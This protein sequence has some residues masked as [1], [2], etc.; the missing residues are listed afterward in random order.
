MVSKLIGGGIF[1][2]GLLITISFPNIRQYQPVSMSWTGV[3]VGV[4]LMGIGLWILTH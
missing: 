1:V 2:L 4:V 3:L